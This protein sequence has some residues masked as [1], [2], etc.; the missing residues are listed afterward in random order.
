[1]S[2]S[3]RLT[4]LVY[5]GGTSHGWGRHVFSCSPIIRSFLR[6]MLSLVIQPVMM[7]SAA[8]P[9]RTSPNNTPYQIVHSHTAMDYSTAQAFEEASVVWLVSISEDADP[10]HTCATQNR[11]GSGHE[12]E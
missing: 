10:R 7:L 8:K 3:V 11:N 6:L 1:M 4:A 9:T 2:E 12:N 5:P